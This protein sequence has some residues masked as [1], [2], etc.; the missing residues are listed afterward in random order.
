MASI[1]I[2]PPDFVL[3]NVLSFHFCLLITART[4]VLRIVPVTLIILPIMKPTNVCLNA[5]MEPLQRFKVGLVLL[6]ALMI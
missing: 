6:I 4:L 3:T 2:Y 5:Q 1:E